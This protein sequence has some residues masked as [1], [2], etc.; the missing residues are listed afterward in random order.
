MVFSVKTRHLKEMKSHCHFC[1][2]LRESPHIL[3][4]H[5]RVIAIGIGLSRTLLAQ[6]KSSVKVIVAHHQRTWWRFEVAACQNGAHAVKIRKSQVFHNVVSCWS[7][8]GLQI[9]S[10][11]ENE[12]NLNGSDDEK[13]LSISW[14]SPESFMH[15][16]WQLLYLWKEALHRVTWL[17][18]NFCTE[19]SSTRNS[20][21]LFNS[22]ISWIPLMWVSRRPFFSWPIVLLV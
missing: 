10:Q 7:Q 18:L 14:N 15:P 4:N 20:W 12:K 19:N 9:W 16:L 22:P 17:S 11:P 3:F 8:F 13:M 1:P 6:T 2:E 21:A 5:L